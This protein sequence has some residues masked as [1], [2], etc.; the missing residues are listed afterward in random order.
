MERAYELAGSGSVSKFE[1]IVQILSREGYS[2]PR[3]SLSGNVL[4]KELRRL[5]T[6]ARAK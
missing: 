5:M 3:S 1:E 2:G 4:R 6:E